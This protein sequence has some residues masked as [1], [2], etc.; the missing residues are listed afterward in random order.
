[1][2]CSL[3]MMAKRAAAH[4]LTVANGGVYEYVAPGL[5]GLEEDQVNKLRSYGFER[6]TFVKGEEYLLLR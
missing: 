4:G 2:E 1:M 5:A 3:V 6:I